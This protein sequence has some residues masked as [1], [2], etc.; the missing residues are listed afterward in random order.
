M[1]AI[2]Y[3]EFGGADVLTLTD[4]EEPHIGPDTMVVKVVAS[5]VNPVDFKI[6][7]GY[8]A[9]LIDGAF[10][11]VPGWD[12]AG[13]VTQVGLDTPE[14]QVGDE[15]LAYARQDSLVGGTLAEFA[16]VPVRTA[17]HKPAGLSFEQ[18]AALPLAGLTA[19][20]SVRRSGVRAGQTVLVHAAAGGVGSIAVQLAVHAGARVVGTASPRNHDFVR[21]LGAEPIEYGDGLVAAARDA[22]PGGFDVILDY[23]GGQG[24]ETAAE[25]LAP[26]GVVTSITD[27]R[28]RTEHG[29]HYVWVRPD[30]AQLAELAQLVADGVVR[31]EIA[32]TFPLERAADAHRAVE[33]G[34]VRG[35][36]VITVVDPA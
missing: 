5:G 12:V 19:L 6:R 23:V 8:L 33:T 15:I 21:S 14:F 22:A 13:V 24:V 18:A 11:I 17:T 1:K 25:L 16:A 36:V 7:E 26:D 4:V 29:G 35:K 27:A 9:G 10:P 31:V 2:T 30:A 34:H 3:T 28:A 20:Q 32:E